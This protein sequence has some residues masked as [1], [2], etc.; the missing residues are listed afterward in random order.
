MQSG[1]SV[2]LVAVGR[3]FWKNQSL[4]DTLRDMK[5][6]DDV[7]FTGHLEQSELT[8]ALGGALA[9]VYVSYF[10]GFGVPIVEAFRSGV[11]VI[12]SNVTSMPEVAGDAAL[13]VNPFNEE[14]I[15][16]AMVR[17]VQDSLL[18][19]DMIAKGE[20]RVKLFDWNSSAEKFWGIINETATRNE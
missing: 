13:Q 9:L 10:E 12:T 18:R 7:I 4:D 8:H 2:K 11:P 1:R 17:I 3:R 19:T 15:A 6:A 20:E 16:S 5:F 14:E